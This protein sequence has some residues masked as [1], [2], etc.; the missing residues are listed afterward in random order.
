MGA[1]IKSVSGE[2]VVVEVKVKLTD[3]M[4]D[5][6][7]AI[8][9]ALNE[10]GQVA[11]EVLLEHFDTD[12]TSIA[13]GALKFT[14]KGRVS[15]KY[16]TPYGE[17]EVP[18]HVYQGTKGGSTYC[19]LDKDARIIHSATPKLAKQISHKY[20]KL[21]VY[22]V[23]TDMESNHGRRLS[24]GYIQSVSE[25]VGVIAQAKEEHW[26]YSTPKQSKAVST[27][28]IGLDGTCMYLRNDGFREAMV[29]TI[30]LYDKQGERLHTTYIAAP[31][32]YGKAQFM[33]RLEREIAHVKQDYPKA[34][35]LGI[36]DGAQDNW[37]FLKRYTTIQV[38]DF[39]H[40]TEY[41]ASAS[42][43]IFPKR[44]E[45]ERLS[46]LEECCHKLKHVQGAASR[47]LTE[48]KGYATKKLSEEEPGKL[49]KAITYFTNQKPRM[50]YSTQVARKLPIGSG[51]TEAACKTI[52]K[53]RLCRSG[54]KWKDHGA[55][56]VL[57]LRCLDRS[58]RWEQFWDKIA[59]YGIAFA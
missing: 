26:S 24:R 20:S 5:G 14:S 17:V 7:D 18:R 9:E 11:T 42:E 34:L 59:H 36:A 55:S 4:L 10:A 21:S 54:M 49:N 58:N 25:A 22:E 28:S 30:A 15:K 31:P 50:K 29:G 12:G 52:I 46:W 3:S 47:I 56:V 27:V 13:I 43:A 57:S 38:T 19:P 6:E 35:Y 2:E 53:Q 23:K 33:A 45:A 48:L 40:A 51:V 16:Q 41:L 39:W 37:T 8:Q 32:E 44:K 1:E